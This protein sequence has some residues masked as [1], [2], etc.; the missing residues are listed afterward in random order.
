MKCK[1]SI[2]FNYKIEKGKNHVSLGDGTIN[3]LLTSIGGKMTIEAFEL[4]LKK[5]NI[6]VLAV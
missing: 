1:E 3:G 2:F 6:Q 4:V 5:F